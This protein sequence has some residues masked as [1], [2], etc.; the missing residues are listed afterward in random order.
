MHT[1]LLNVEHFV[2][3]CNTFSTYFVMCPNFV[4]TMIPIIFFQP[5]HPLQNLNAS[6]LKWGHPL[7][8]QLPS[9]HIKVLTPSILLKSSK[10]SFQFLTFHNRVL[11]PHL[12]HDSQNCVSGFVGP[13]LLKNKVDHKTVALTSGFPLSQHEWK[14][15]RPLGFFSQHHYSASCLFLLT[16]PSDLSHN[17]S[18]FMCLS[19]SSSGFPFS[20]SSQTFRFLLSS[21]LA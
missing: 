12:W 18:V 13:L 4:Q 2:S 16:G 6:S 15:I 3:N 1:A 17:T 20:Q 14:N 5:Q 11:S 8:Q 21:R 10:K 19:L 7:H 9:F